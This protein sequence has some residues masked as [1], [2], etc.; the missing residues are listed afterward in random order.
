MVGSKIHIDHAVHI[1]Q[2]DTDA[3]DLID[4]LHFFQF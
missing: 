4:F 2:R 1:D 3:Y